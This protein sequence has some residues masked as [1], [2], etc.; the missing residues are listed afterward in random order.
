MAV[1]ET[2][3]GS[4]GSTTYRAKVRLKGLP[5]QTA[6]FKRKT[7]AQRWVQK[8]ESDLREGRHFHLIEASKHLFSELAD[9]Y[10]REVLAHRTKNVANSLRHIKYWSSTLGHLS[11]V[12]ITPAT[13]V[14]RR[15]ELLSEK[16]RRKKLRS[17]ATV[18]RYLA[19]LSHAFS[20]AMRDWQWVTEN[21]VSKITKPREPRGRE[22]FLSDAERERLLAATQ[23]SSSPYLHVV[24]VLAIST[25]MRRGEIMN[26]RW[27]DVDFERQM[28]LISDT[29]NGTS[30]SVPLIPLTHDLLSALA[31]VRRFDTALVF[32]SAKGDKPVELKR[33]WETA[34]DVACLGDRTAFD[35]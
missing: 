14:A 29:K 18:V 35:G 32:P 8:V 23:Q 16:T 31:K 33:P 22:R 34:V 24:V 1:I 19:T 25:G 15:T 9:R 10:I 30:R 6:T 4:D 12:D 11:L 13:I 28:V 27:S 7:D 5:P 2:R 3:R 20:I 26:M 17:P 21:P